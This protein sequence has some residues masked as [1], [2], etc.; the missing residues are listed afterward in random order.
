MSKLLVGLEYEGVILDSNNR[1]TQWSE[2]SRSSREYLSLVTTKVR[3]CDTS[4]TDRYSC[5]AEIRTAP[6]SSI[7][8]AASHLSRY[9]K[10]TSNHF[11]NCGYK[12]HWGELEI[13]LDTHY[14]ILNSIDKT[15]CFDNRITNKTLYKKSLTENSYNQYKVTDNNYRGG[16]L[17]INISGITR[18]QFFTFMRLINNNYNY[19]LKSKYRLPNIFR[20]KHVNGINIFEYVSP[21]LDFTSIDNAI[22]SLTWLYGLDNYKISEFEKYCENDFE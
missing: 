20:Q 5:L 13:P 22:Y 9:L 11:G 12:I 17:H 10:Q 4:I 14:A 18:N 6:Q 16:G 19:S 3:D 15:I 8:M 7:T 1:I 21:Y 2:I